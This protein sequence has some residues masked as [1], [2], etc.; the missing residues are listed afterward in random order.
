M[1]QIIDCPTLDCR[2]SKYG[3]IGLDWI[4]NPDFGTVYN[5]YSYNGYSDNVDIVILLSL[6]ISPIY[7]YAI[8]NLLDVVI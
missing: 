5:G 1:N 8:Q 3:S 6:S 4:G 7:I 2:L